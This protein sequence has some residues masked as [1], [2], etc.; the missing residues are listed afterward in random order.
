[1]QQIFSKSEA[2]AHAK[3]LKALDD[4]IILE[5]NQLLAEGYANGMKKVTLS[6]PHGMTDPQWKAL[7][8]IIHDKSYIVNAE[9]DQR[10]G[11]WYVI[12]L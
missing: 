8:E 12:E 10:D 5:V 1:M 6:R 7:G 3:A 11:E 2:Q 4:Q 9:S